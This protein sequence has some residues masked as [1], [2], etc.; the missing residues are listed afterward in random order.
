[1]RRFSLAFQVF[2]SIMLVAVGA[3]AGVG[4]IARDALSKAFDSYLASLPTP[5]GGAARPHMGRVMLGAAEQTFVAGVDRSVYLGAALAVVAA[6]VVAFLVARY[7]TRPILRLE[8]AAKDLA[9]GDLSHRVNASGPAEVAALGDAFNHMADSLEEAEMLRRRL[10]ADVAH[11]LRNPIAVLRIQAEGMAEGIM[12][13]EPPVLDSLVEELQHLSSLVDDLQELSSAEAGRL[14]YEMEPI[15]LAELAR[16][17]AERAARI[18]ADGVRVTSQGLT[19]EAIIIG[20]QRRLSEVMRNLLGNA[21]KY[22][23]QGDVSVVIQTIDGEQVEVAV[24]DTGAGISPQDLPHVFERF[25]RAD[26]ARSAR[27]G[28]AG[29]G[30]AISRRIVEDHGGAV[31]A[32]AAAGGGAIVGFRLPLA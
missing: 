12:A 2:L 7:L 27:T 14:N 22:T 9:A 4:L 10:V 18:A 26:R 15:D 25:Y 17:E 16:R 28:G 31:F 1:M 11:E 6:G 21:L 5:M 30:L 20:D 8:D 29:L 24:H 3:V 23:A 13:A 19:S 32:D